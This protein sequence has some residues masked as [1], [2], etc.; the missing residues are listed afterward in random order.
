MD[1]HHASFTPSASTASAASRGPMVKWPPIGRSARSVPERACLASWKAPCYVCDR[2]ISRPPSM[3][4]GRGDEADP[5]RGVL[6]VARGENGDAAHP[7]RRRPVATWCFHARGRRP[8]GVFAARAGTPGD[9][10][11][12]STVRDMPILLGVHRSA[13]E[14]VE[15]LG[16]SEGE[17]G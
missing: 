10:G 2:A 17:A 11:R 5:A 4:T 6:R 15:P 3:N 16:V 14:I 12:R 1:R 8:V 9:R 13:R 7:S